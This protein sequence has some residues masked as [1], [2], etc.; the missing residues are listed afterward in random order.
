[1]PSAISELY[2]PLIARD[3]DLIPDAVRSFRAEHDADALWSA[4]ARFAVLAYAPSQHARH[5][6]LAALAARDVRDGMSDDAYVAL[7]TE[8]AVY[9][10]SSRQPWSEPPISDP[11]AIDADQRG[12]V[13]ELREAVAA[14]DRLRA[15][16]WLAKRID[17]PTL[18]ADFFA[19]AADDFSDLGHNLIVAVA[20]WRLA[21]MFD[22]RGRFATLRIATW[23]WTARAGSRSPEPQGEVEVT[24][25]WERLLA[26]FM[27]AR[28]E[29]EAAHRLFLLDAGERASEIAGGSAVL[30][31]VR[32]QLGATVDLSGST[33]DGGGQDARSPMSYP[34]A[35]DYGERLKIEALMATLRARHPEL[36]LDGVREA[37]EINCENNDFG[38]WSFA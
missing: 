21:S 6:V 1:M 23:E 16:R 31:R 5:A 28:G 20:A 37:A 12:D 36:S 14:G 4:I 33:P 10:A 2:E 24:P 34:L 22:P 9:A 11:P 8:C 7:L 35:R 15:E 32:R 27:A 3:L 17:D 18:A 38:E 26:E 19:V 13:E 30:Q 25:L 29:I